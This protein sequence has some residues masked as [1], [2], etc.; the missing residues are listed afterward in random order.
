M[1]KNSEQSIRT[2]YLYPSVGDDD[3]RY[4][5]ATGLVRSLQ[6]KMLTKGTLADMAGAE[7]Y[8]SAAEMLSSSE[9][10]PAG[11]NLELADME[12]VLLTQRSA[13]RKLFANLMIDQEIVGLFR[14]RDD[15]ANMRLALRRKLT[16]KPIGIDY[17]DDGNVPAEDFEHIFE[18]ENYDP[19]PCYMQEAIEAAVLA[20]YQNKDVR[21]IDYTLD[22]TYYQYV[23][24]RTLQLKNIF[25]CELI[26]M[27]I[28]FVN[29]NTM[30][31]LKLTDRHQRD[32]FIEGGYI[33][34]QK[35]KA[36][37]DSDYETIKP[38]FSPTQYSDIVETGVN[39]IISNKSFLKLEQKCDE[40]LAGYLK[41][42]D[43]I[44]A[45]PQPVIAYL[46]MKE[47][48]IRNIRLIMTAKKNAMDKELVLDRIGR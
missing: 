17:S 24:D 10:A 37:V 25:L 35:L 21:Q 16:E 40:H 39:Y 6:T 34:L 32:V 48:E 45:G 47:A 18:E 23:L 20:Y 30:L 36:G 13:V 33:E 42:T 14:V 4:G 41:L 38:S 1:A 22:Q 2:F 46:L 26:K 8:N 7:N 5:F 11:D 12:N 27:Q 29:I 31:R 44:T 15:F 19:L 3:W 28:D 9:Y 43:L